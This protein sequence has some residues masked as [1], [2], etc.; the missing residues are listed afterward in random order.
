MPDLQEYRRALIAGYGDGEGRAIYSLLVE[1]YGDLSRTEILLGKRPDA[2]A[3]KQIAAAIER[4]L[5][6]EPVQ[7]VTGEAFFYGR[8]FAVDSRVLIPRRETEELVH[9]VINDNRNRRKLNIL[10]LGVGSGC[11]AVS[12]AC[13][14]PD[15]RAYAVDVSLDALDVARKNSALNGADVSMAYCDILNDAELPFTGVDFDLIISN[16]PYV[17]RSEAANMRANVL[18][19]EPH[20]ALFADDETPLLCY[21]ACLHLA[22]PRLRAG[23]AVYVEINEA[24]GVETAELFIKHGFT[25]EVLKD[26]AGK[27]RI[28]RAKM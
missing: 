10:D 13:E 5:R 25:P 16:P 6:G 17:R 21:E 7:Y 26:M 28:I 4:T 20:L 18:D 1:H 22:K 2:S 8:R 3:E 27:N 24:L 23:G 11:I 12:L 19:Y 14:L 9:V 15:A